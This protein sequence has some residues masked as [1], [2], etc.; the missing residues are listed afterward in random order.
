MRS[1]QNK[2]IAILI[3]FLDVIY[4]SPCIDNNIRIRKRNGQNKYS[5]I[6][7]DKS[8]FTGSIS[9]NQLLVK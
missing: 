5:K 4:F 2:I 1:L 7:N 8:S 6:S 3:S 9:H